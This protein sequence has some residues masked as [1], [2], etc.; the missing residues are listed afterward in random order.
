MSLENVTQGIDR[1]DVILRY[2][3]GYFSPLDDADKHSEM[4]KIKNES[5]KKDSLNQINCKKYFILAIRSLI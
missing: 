1:K 4:R 2:I 5:T 3:E